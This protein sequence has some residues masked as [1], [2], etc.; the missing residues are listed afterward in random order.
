MALQRELQLAI[1]PDAGQSE[2]GGTCHVC[3]IPR[4]F[5]GQGDLG[6]SATRQR[7]GAPELAL[8]LDGEALQLLEAQLG[9]EQERERDHLRLAGRAPQAPQLALLAARPG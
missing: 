5:S 3:N 6:E 9:L 4:A 1:G 2:N 7:L 8:Q